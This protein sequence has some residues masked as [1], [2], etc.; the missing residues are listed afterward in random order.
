[1]DRYYIFIQGFNF[2]ILTGD[3][4]RSGADLDNPTRRV[5]FGI[6]GIRTFSMSEN[7]INNKV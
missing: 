7:N 3:K 1:M 2:L 6:P 5:P 4:G